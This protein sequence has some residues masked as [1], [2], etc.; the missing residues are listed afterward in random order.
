MSACL[1]F[2]MPTGK[3]GIAWTDS[4]LNPGLFGCGKVSPACQNCYAEMMA[5]RLA[6]MGNADY[7]GATVDGAWT[8]RVRVGPAETAAKRIL[9]VPKR[10]DGDRLVNADIS[11]LEPSSGGDDPLA[12]N[13]V[14]TLQAFGREVS[15]AE[16]ALSLGLPVATA[17]LRLHNAGELVHERGDMW[18]TSE[19]RESRSSPAAAGIASRS[20]ELRA[21][22][23][24]VLRRSAGSWLTAR[25]IAA[26]VGCAAGDVY[27]AVRSVGAVER[28]NGHYRVG[29]AEAI[30]P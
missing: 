25:K 1:Y 18:S 3:C 6:R 29:S 10:R 14:A 16:V 28:A 8:G 27:P 30:R 15:T 5:V 12:G 21:Q 23:L 17:R 9:A 4:T 22:V 7:A 2:P 26:A 24:A 13:V 19:R 11:Q 20:A